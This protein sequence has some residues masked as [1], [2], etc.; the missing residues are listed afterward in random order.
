MV[1]NYCLVPESTQGFSLM[2]EGRKERTASEEGWEGKRR[3]EEALVMLGC[4]FSITD[5]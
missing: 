3:I 5:T 4:A 1:V 2:F